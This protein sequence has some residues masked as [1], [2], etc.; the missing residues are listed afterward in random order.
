MNIDSQSSMVAD[1]DC[2]A[3]AANTRRSKAG[4]NGD[5]TTACSTTPATQSKHCDLDAAGCQIPQ[6]SIPSW[7]GYWLGWLAGGS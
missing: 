4:G 1:S 7:G 3:V 6:R 2:F 5:D